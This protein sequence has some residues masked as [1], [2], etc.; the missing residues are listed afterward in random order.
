MEAKICD[1]SDL[2]Q[3]KGLV[4]YVLN[5]YGRI[6]YMFNNAGIA[7]AGEARDIDMDDW[8]KTLAVNLNG[9][10]NGVAGVYP[11]M[12]RQGFGHI[13]N[14]A[15]IAGLFPVTMRYLMSHQSLQ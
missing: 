15:S 12:A 10:I 6:D 5:K 1:V 3:V 8:N 14:T 7:I 11:I 13:I 4:D 2:K 9:V